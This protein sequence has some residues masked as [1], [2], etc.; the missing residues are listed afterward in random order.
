LIKVIAPQMWMVYVARSGLCIELLAFAPGFFR[1]VW[2]AGR[3]MWNWKA[4]QPQQLDHD[5]TQ[6]RHL[7]HELANHP[8]QAISERLRFVQAGQARLQAK[9][10]FFAGGVDRLGILPLLFAMGVQ[11][12]AYNDAKELPLWQAGLGLYFAVTYLVGIIGQLM[13]LRLQLYEVVLSEAM[14]ASERKS[15]SGHARRF[16]SNVK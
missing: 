4:E 6:F 11:F 7:A 15:P 3:S 5:F 1:G 8:V 14:I 13:R 16:P 9:L 2:V 10:S 12:K